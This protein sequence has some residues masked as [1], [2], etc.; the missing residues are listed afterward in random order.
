MRELSAIA[1][2]ASSPP[3]DCWSLVLPVCEATLDVFFLFI[4]DLRCLA[5]SQAV[6]KSKIN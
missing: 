3:P 6:D 4:G 2:G 5:M 1:A